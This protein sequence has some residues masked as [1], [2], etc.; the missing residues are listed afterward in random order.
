[1]PVPT[2]LLT[3]RSETTQD[4]TRITS[5]GPERAASAGVCGGGGWQKTQC[6][7]PKC[8]LS[9]SSSLQM[10]VVR[11]CK[12][13]VN[14]QTMQHH[15]PDISHYCENISS[16][17][18]YLSK[19]FLSK[20]IKHWQQT[21]LKLTWR[22]TEFYRSLFSLVL[23]LADQYCKIQPKALNQCSVPVHWT[24]SEIDTSLML[25]K[26]TCLLNH[27]TITCDTQVISN[28]CQSCAALLALAQSPAGRAL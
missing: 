12:T 23:L 24:T 6:Y 13:S 22:V 25:M 8:S 27:L 20:L 21:I 10:M 16:Y 7:I 18:E 28:I 17:S 3:E 4:R 11:S 19:H 1:M 2:S 26:P 5:T 15:I 9:I 14:C